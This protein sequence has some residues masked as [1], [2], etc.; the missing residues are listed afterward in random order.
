[1]AGNPWT[2]KMRGGRADGAHDRDSHNKHEHCDH[3]GGLAGEERPQEQSSDSSVVGTLIER[4]QSRGV[5][6]LAR[7]VQLLDHVVPTE[8][9]QVQKSEVKQGDY[10]GGGEGKGGHGDSKIQ[11]ARLVAQ[12]DAVES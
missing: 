5:G 1:M 9:L 2:R 8:G 4:E 12:R 11:A 7:L 10:G 6:I 3:H